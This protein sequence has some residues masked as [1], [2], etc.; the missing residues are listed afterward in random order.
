M[1]ENEERKPEFLELDADAF[2]DNWRN[3]IDNPPVD[4]SPPKNAT[5]ILTQT[6]DMREQGN[7]IMRFDAW[8]GESGI[9]V[10]TRVVVFYPVP[11]T[12]IE[13]FFRFKRRPWWAF[14][15]KP[16]AEYINHQESMVQRR[17][18]SKHLVGSFVIPWGVWQSFEAQRL[19][20]DFP[21]KPNGKGGDPDPKRPWA[22]K[23]TGE[24]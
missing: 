17:I 19:D 13:A 9:H 18:I 15:K 24:E 8:Q 1:S 20:P 22:Q 10:H 14:W 16:D 7:F 5:K 21:T 4:W 6:L 3:W 2:E 12:L 11:S 23:P